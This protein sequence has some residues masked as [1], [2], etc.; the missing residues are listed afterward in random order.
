MRRGR[1][2]S[3]TCDQA[4]I[5]PWRPRVRFGRAT[6][7][8]R[9]PIA[10]YTGTSATERCRSGQIDKKTGNRLRQ[11][12]IDEVTREPVEGED[13]GRGYE[14][15]KNAY[16]RVDDDE[17][18]ALA[19]GGECFDDRV[20]PHVIGCDVGDVARSFDHAREASRRL[21]LKYLAEYMPPPPSNPCDYSVFVH[22]IRVMS[23]IAALR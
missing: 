11:Q 14:Y 21:S 8:S 9:C 2:P 15:A 20:H 10:L 1:C 5:S 19:V 7:S 16:I 6:S 4:E 22:A 13:K 23:R 17:L 18:D 12:L 3:G